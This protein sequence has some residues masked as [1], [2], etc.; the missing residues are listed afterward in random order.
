[1]N[2]ETHVNQRA[3]DSKSQSQNGPPATFQTV[4]TTAFRLFFPIQA[5]GLLSLRTVLPPTSDTSS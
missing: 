1:M 5:L 2:H 3:D 4:I